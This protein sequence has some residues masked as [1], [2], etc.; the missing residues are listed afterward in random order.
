MK[1]RVLIAALLLVGCD[2]IPSPLPPKP[3]WKMG[4]D[5]VIFKETFLACLEKLPRGPE[6]TG[7]FTDWDEVVVECRRTAREMAK[8]KVPNK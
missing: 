3:E 5:L 2:K 4:T 1:K 7:V 6:K 8:V